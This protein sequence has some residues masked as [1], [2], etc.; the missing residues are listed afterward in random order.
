MLPDVLEKGLLLVICGTAPGRY[1]GE[2]GAYYAGRGNKFWP[3]MAEIGL[4]P[5][6][7]P[8]QFREVLF[9]GIGLTNIE[10]TKAGSD[11]DVPLSKEA[12]A[13]FHRKMQYYKP[14]VIAFN[15]KRSAQVAY[16]HTVSYG[17]QD[18]PMY[19]SDVLV[20][21]ST[22]GAASGFWDPRYWH[23]MAAYVKGLQ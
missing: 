6:L 2:T 9:Y 22:S 19:E 18:E 17:L 7:N 4:L 20:L 11:K 10:Q 14:Q 16:S 3:I 12:V 1:S 13:E 5:L 21:P 8:E 23:D 15:G